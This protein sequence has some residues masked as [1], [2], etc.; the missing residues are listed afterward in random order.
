M[1]FINV[2]YWYSD[3]PRDKHKNPDRWLTNADSTIKIKI[4]KSGELLYCYTYDEEHVST[5]H[6]D[7]LLSIE[8]EGINN[9]LV[10][11]THEDEEV[12]CN[13]IKPKG[14]RNALV[15]VLE[16]SEEELVLE[17]VDIIKTTEK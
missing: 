14:N 2:R 15:C 5:I 1:T 3:S 13:R 7:F 8:P 17:S 9:K 4:S 11:R 10:L 12:I 6:I 16:D